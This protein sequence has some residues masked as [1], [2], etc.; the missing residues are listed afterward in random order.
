[1]VRG[2]LRQQVDERRGRAHR[3]AQ[4]GLILGGQRLEQL[5]HPAV[6]RPLQLQALCAPAGGDIHERCASVLRVGEPRNEV[7]SLQS[8]NQFRH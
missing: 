5:I 2:E 3:Q 7:F 8:S 1:M 4:R 6:Q